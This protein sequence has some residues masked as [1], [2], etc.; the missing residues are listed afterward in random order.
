MPKTKSPITRSGYGN[1]WRSR[2]VIKHQGRGSSCVAVADF[3]PASQVLTI[4]FQ[5]RGTYEYYDVS[6]EVW[7]A[8]RGAASQGE[9]FNHSIK[10]VYPYE[11]IA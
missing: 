10:E 9:F 8:L 3:D 2:F 6:L 5:Q 1:Q 4:E 11:R 7:Q